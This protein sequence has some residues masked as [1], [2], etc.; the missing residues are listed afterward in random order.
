[1]QNLA[2]L[3]S[4]SRTRNIMCHVSK[5]KINH[6]TMTSDNAPF[7]GSLSMV[8]QHLILP[9]CI[10][11]LTTLASAVAENWAPNIENSRMVL[12]MPH[13]VIVFLSLSSLR[14]VN[15]YVLLLLLLLAPFLKPS[16]ILVEIAIS[17]HP[18]CIWRQRWRWPHHSFAEIF[19]ITKLKSQRYH[20]AFTVW[21]YVSPFLIPYWLVTDVRTD[22]H[23]TTAHTVLA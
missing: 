18:T 6:M 4:F 20:T 5:F 14:H 1:M 8:G 7:M 21:S 3:N 2:N 15:Q 11:N 10:Q 16:E 19:G 9:T 17:A 12:T 23:T 13:I 22:R